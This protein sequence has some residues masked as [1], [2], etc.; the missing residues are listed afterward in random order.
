MG[1][2]EGRQQELLDAAAKLFSEKGYEAATI[3]DISSA[4]GRNQAMVYYYFPDKQALLYNAMA[5][6][7]KK[8]ME[9]ARKI[10]K[11]QVPPDRKLELLIKE[12]INQLSADRP[13]Q[14]IASSE[15]R[16]LVP[17]NRQKFIATRDKYEKIFRKVIQEGMEQ[18]QF[19]Q[20]DVKITGIFILMLINSTTRWYKSGG[21]YSLDEICA[22]LTNFINK[23]IKP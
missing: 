10:E 15:L 18:G 13:A 11:M 16:H 8:L 6:G 1:D 7:L 19:Q 17:Q 3:K 21:K 23:A 12:H 5:N 22:L 2:R 4:I 20:A 14:S 9:Q